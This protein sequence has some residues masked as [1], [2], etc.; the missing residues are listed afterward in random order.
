MRE[1]DFENEIRKFLNKKKIYHFKFWGGN[2]KT[3]H[4]SFI[5]T[6]KGVPDLICVV[7]GVFVGLEIKNEKGKPTEEQ[8]KNLG[9]INACG[10]LGF[11]VKP[12]DFELLQVCLNQLLEDNTQKDLI[13]QKF[14]SI[15]K[16]Y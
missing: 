2:Y 6:K 12:K 3:T 16:N 13:R 14:L 8:I 15:S 1:K 4:G 7:N 11:V 9:E 10:G 5:M